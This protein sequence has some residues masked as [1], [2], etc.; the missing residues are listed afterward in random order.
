MI[1]RS[2]L[3]VVATCNRIDM[4]ALGC[5]RLV[6]LQFI[7]WSL[8]F[9]GGANM[10]SESFGYHSESWQMSNFFVYLRF[11]GI[12]LNQQFVVNLAHK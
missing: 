5:Q 6:S 10:K 8:T 4:G 9:C 12:A 11:V 1:L 2:A 7:T 3:T